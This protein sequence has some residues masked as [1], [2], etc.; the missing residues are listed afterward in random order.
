MNLWRRILVERRAIVLPLAV[1]LIANVALYAL[2]VLPLEHSVSTA[3]EQAI[4]SMALLAGAKRDAT[5]A[6][7]ARVSTAQADDELKRF[8]EGVL[9]PDFPHARDVADFWLDR[10]AR[11]A[12]VTKKDSQYD[13]ELVKESRLV[14]VKG[15]VVLEGS[16][17]NIRRF[18]YATE[19][20][21][22][23]IVIERVELSEGG[24]TTPGAADTLGVTLDLATYY[25]AASGR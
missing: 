14:R 15:K 5:N 25:V 18:L 12:G 23:F 1:V 7:N 3:H 9:A 10:T 20:A 8:Y 16:Y 11:Q 6:R 17:G 22:E 4:G 2:A 24:T 21:H 13:Y 19:S